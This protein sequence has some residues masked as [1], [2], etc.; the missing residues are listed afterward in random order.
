MGKRGQKGKIL[1]M[2]IS[3]R[4]DERI[5]RNLALVKVLPK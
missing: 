3:R 4:Q 5:I 1:T 2:E